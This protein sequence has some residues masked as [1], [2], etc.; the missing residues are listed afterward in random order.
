MSVYRM[1]E[2]GVHA[3]DDNNIPLIRNAIQCF[4]RKTAQEI[5]YISSK[6]FYFIQII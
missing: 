1:R 5:L 6:Y 4:G 3:T 2:S